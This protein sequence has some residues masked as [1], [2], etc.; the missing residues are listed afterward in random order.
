MNKHT[1]LNNIAIL[2]IAITLAVIC[3][4]GCAEEEKRTVATVTV[5]TP[6][7]GSEI[8]ANQE[9]AINFDNPASDVMVNGTLATGSGKS[10]K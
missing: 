5:V 8:P 10:W 7:E 6:P 4:V 9:I 1:H 3:I 2:M